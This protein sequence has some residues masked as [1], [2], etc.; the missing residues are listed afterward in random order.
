MPS[1]IQIA[2]RWVGEGEPCFVIAEAGSNHNQ[3]FEQAKRLI[4]IAASAGADAVKF[5]LFRANRLY[6]K[7]AGV[8]NYLKL[9]KSIYDLIA[10]MELPYDW[11]PE[12]ADVCAKKN[13]LFM[14]SAF[15]EESADRLDPYVQVHK[16]ASYEMT[17]L[18]LVRHV[19][20]KKKPVIVS[21]GTADLVEVQEMAE[22]FQESGNPNLILM[23]CT[24][25]YPAP[26]NSLNVRAIETLRQA[27]HLPVGLSDHSRS[28]LAGPL[29][30]VGV[31]AHLIEK[32]VTLSN[33]LPGPDHS[34]ALE[35]KEFSFMVQTIREVEQAL[36]K[37][38]KAVHPV[39][40]E[41]HHF[42]RRSIFAAR[43]IPQGKSITPSHLVILRNGNHPAGLA[44]RLWDQVVGKAAVRD[45]QAEK[46]IMEED[47]A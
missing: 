18:P 32:H 42:A 46:P 10:S 6:P 13:I 39:E 30:A 34:F 14:A 5:Q 15:D 33:H 22:S 19:A 47:V 25:A 12:L 41:L 23:Q 36:G 16:I 40:M 28:P 43:S 9:N 20:E 1:R 4:E 35:P 27:F 26:L 21:T 38:E 8:S 31:G 45:I 7:N 29:A 44:P 17:H 37:P 11:I 2:D 3:N 24:A